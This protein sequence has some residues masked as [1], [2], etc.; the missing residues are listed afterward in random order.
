MAKLY[1]V[2]A[3]FKNGLHLE[4]L[5]EDLAQADL[6]RATLVE[7]RKHNAS[8]EIFDNAGRQAQIEGAELMV[9][10]LVDLELET[11]GAAAVARHVQDTQRRLGILAPAQE[12]PIPN[13]P[14]SPPRIGE[15]PSRF[16]Q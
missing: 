14:D 12:Q 1:I 3:S 9:I 2:R 7:A 4:F 15:V 5:Y 16:Q 6:C 13:G 11:V 8:A 10:Q